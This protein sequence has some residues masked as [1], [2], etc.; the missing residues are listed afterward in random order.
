MNL[1][2][3]KASSSFPLSSTNHARMKSGNSRTVYG[4]LSTTSTSRKR[5]RGGSFPV[6]TFDYLETVTGFFKKQLS[7]RCPRRQIVATTG[8]DDLLA[9]FVLCTAQQDN[10][11]SSHSEKS[12]LIWLIVT[13]KVSLSVFAA[14]LGSFLVN[15][16]GSA[17]ERCN[18]KGNGDITIHQRRIVDFANTSSGWKQRLPLSFEIL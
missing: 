12:N 10:S 13:L 4:N 11:S 7:L 8:R 14:E 17:F 3:Q 5:S 1:N 18:L 6:E 15:L 9:R 2:G 16:H